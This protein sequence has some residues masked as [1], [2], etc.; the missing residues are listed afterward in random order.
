MD[1]DSTINAIKTI[2]EICNYIAIIIGKALVS[3]VFLR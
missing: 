1:T 2:F 3:F